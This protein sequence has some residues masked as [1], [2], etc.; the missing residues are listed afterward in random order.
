M[1]PIFAASNYKYLTL[2]SKRCRTPL[3][4]SHHA[5]FED[6]P[7][8][9]NDSRANQR[10]RQM[11]A[12]AYQSFDYQS[13]EARIQRAK[14]RET[15]IGRLDA[16]KTVIESQSVTKVDLPL[17]KPR[18]FAQGELPKSADGFIPFERAVTEYASCS[19]EGYC[20]ADAFETATGIFYTF[21][22]LQSNLN[23]RQALTISFPCWTCC[24]TK[25]RIY[26]ICKVC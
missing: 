13:N 12:E 24:R 15:E 18:S 16:P 3:T 25:Q 9:V 8:H 22:S 11:R 4:M 6:M 21:I 23:V 26:L 17:K 14:D 20:P 19:A 5:M 10:A 2:D 1:L 7:K